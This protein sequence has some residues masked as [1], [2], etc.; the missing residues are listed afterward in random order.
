MAEILKDSERRLVVRLGSR[1]GRWTKLIFDRD[2]GRMWAERH[3]RLWPTRTIEIALSDIAAIEAKR[4]RLVITTRAGTQHSLVGDAAPA[5]AAAR[6]RAFALPDGAPPIE[7]ARSAGWKSSR[8]IR[9]GAALAAAALLLT[10]AKLIDLFVLPTCDSQRARDT[11][12]DL[13]QA[14]S[15]STIG[16]SG[17]ADVSRGRSEMRCMADVTVEGDVATVGYRVYWDGW[18]PMVR[19][20]GAIGTARLDP[21]RLRAIDEAY[22]AF[23][24]RAQDAYRTGEPPRQSDPA[25]SGLLATIFDLPVWPMKTLAGS[26]IDEAI[27]W[28]NTA[29]T[30]GSVYVLAGTGVSDFT[31]LPS[32]PDIERRLRAN[33]VAFSDEYGRYADFQVTLLAAIAEAQAS[34]LAS[35]PQAEV[36]AEAF[37]RKA[38]DIKPLFAQALSS[39]FI[40]LVYDGLSE[41]WRLERLAALSRVAPIAAR[42]LS[43]EDRARVRDAALRTLSYFKNDRIKARITEIAATIGGR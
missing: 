18:S 5:E 10:A 35:G 30:V 36:E 22:D 15:K 1:G 39:N 42:A 24:A 13:L 40:A 7:A 41:R 34:H 26:E 23:M 11:V 43:G 19:I 4:A 25:V 31:N 17:F 2:A 21:A 29:D 16:L 14:K 6:M 32:G 3:A 12:H 33:V 28:F 37:R 20:T 38:E 9:I 27:R 8:A